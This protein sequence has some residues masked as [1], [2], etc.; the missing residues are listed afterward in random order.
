MQF[1]NRFSF[2]DTR[3]YQQWAERL[4]QFCAYVDPEGFPLETNEPS[5]PKDYMLSSE[6]I[7]KLKQRYGDTHLIIDPISGTLTTR[8][9]FEEGMQQIQ[10]QIRKQ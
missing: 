9:I 8:E 5:F 3:K 7:Q 10:N 6:I 2:S 1:S 4:W